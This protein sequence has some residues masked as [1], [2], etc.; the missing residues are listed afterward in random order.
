MIERNR[1]SDDDFA[2]RRVE[3][4]HSGPGA[5][6]H[7]EG[8]DVADIWGTGPDDVFAVAG[9]PLY[10]QYELLHYDGLSWTLVRMQDDTGLPHMVGIEDTIMVKRIEKR[11]NKLVLLSNHKDYLPIILNREEAGEVRII[12]KVIWVC[13]EI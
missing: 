4:E 6:H 11:P 12:G 3:T 2:T 9:S 13:R 1:I 10:L 8:R 7:R 5:A